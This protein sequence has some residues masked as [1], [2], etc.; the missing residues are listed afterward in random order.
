MLV[1]TTLAASLLLG[2]VWFL[3]ACGVD[4]ADR[5]P[6]SSSLDVGTGGSP[7]AGNG[8][9]N[10][11]RRC[12]NKLTGVI[13]D[14]DPRTHPDFEPGDKKLTSPAAREG[15][16][17][18]YMAEPGIVQPTLGPD[19]KPLYAKDPN[20]GSL[21]TYGDPW[22]QSWYRDTAGIN[23]SMDFAIEFSDPDGDDVFTFDSG[24]SQFFPIDHML[25]G[26]WPNY[27]PNDPQGGLHNYSFTYEL[28]AKFLYNKPG[29]I[30]RFSGDD[31]VWV[32]ID[33]KLVVD[34]GGI[35]VTEVGE[36]K[37][38][39]L[40]LELN[41]EY[42]LDFFWAERHVSQ[43]NFRIDTSMEFSDCSVAVPR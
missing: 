11:A 36:V 15:V 30:F 12:D 18:T 2:S 7:Q 16:T 19:F 6:G 22:F 29:M 38:D 43:S 21:T 26:N 27:P 13:R 17:K 8:V 24:A 35:H 10:S 5:G 3:G 31:D 41:E 20:A 25:L 14:F 23:A 28:H 37:L 9:V 33:G 34:L 1:R 39:K 40:G 42:Q 4:A 32:F